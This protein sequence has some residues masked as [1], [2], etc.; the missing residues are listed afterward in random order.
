MFCKRIYVSERTRGNTGHL[1]T[2]KLKQIRLERSKNVIR[3]Y[4]SGHYKEIFFTNEKNFT[5][6]ESFCKQN[7]RI[8]V[9]NSYE[10]K[11]KV[12]RVQEAITRVL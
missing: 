1:L 11:D 10:V 8:Y 6:E 3:V 9:R 2:D 12:L 7:N 5:V 4:G